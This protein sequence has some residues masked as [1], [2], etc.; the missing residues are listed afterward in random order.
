MGL[1]GMAFL[2]PIHI[3]E[4]LEYHSSHSTPSVRIIRMSKISFLFE[5]GGGY[6]P[7]ILTNK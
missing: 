2:L 1:F 6:I 5:N 3:V 4:S 7:V